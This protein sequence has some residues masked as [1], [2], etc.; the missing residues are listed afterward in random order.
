MHSV[1]VSCVLYMLIIQSKLLYK[2]IYYFHI[3]IGIKK[4]LMLTYCR[5]II[6]NLLSNNNITQNK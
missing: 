1:Y 2:A 4:L 3:L 6:I 5:L